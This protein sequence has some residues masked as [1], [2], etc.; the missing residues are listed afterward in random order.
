[1]GMVIVIGIAVVALL[2]LLGV[3]WFVLDSNRRVKRFARSAELVPGR[4]GRAPAEWAKSTAP[5]AMLHQRIRYAISDVHNAGISV[6]VPVP[7]S[8]AAAGKGDDLGDLDDTVFD[9]DDRVIAAAALPT[10]EKTKALAALEPAVAA[11]E[12]LTGT[13]WESP[14]AERSELLGTVAARLRR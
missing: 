3:L 14:A 13:L 11:L 9:L 1:M 10:E 4:P 12:G 7:E 8:S 6:A 5:E 2:V